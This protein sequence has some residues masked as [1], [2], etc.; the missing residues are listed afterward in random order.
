MPFTPDKPSSG[1]VPDSQPS[2]GNP[3]KDYYARHENDSVGQKLMDMVIA[4]KDN[5]MTGDD[6]GAANLAIPMEAAPAALQK[7]A[8]YLGG[9]GLGNAAARVAANTGIGAAQGGMADGAE[10]AKKGALIGG[11][12]STA[13][14]ALGGL[15]GLAKWGG[16]NL[17]RMTAPQ[18]DAYLDDPSAVAEMRNALED[19]SKMPALQDQAADAIRNSRAV[20]KAQ[21]L[22]KASQLRQALDGKYV[23][24]NPQELSG[25]S[26]EADKELA[27]F[28]Y[29]TPGTPGEAVMGDDNVMTR[30]N[31]TS[32]QTSMS[33]AVSV[34][35]NDANQLKRYLQGAAK[36]VPGSVTDPV[37]AARVKA[38]GQA[39]ANLRGGIEGVAPEAA[40]L[41]KQMQ[42]G[43]LLQEALRKGGKNS[44]LAFISS[45]SPDRVATLARAENAGAGGLLDFGNKL[46]AA[47]TMARP[48]QGSGIP[49][50][51]NKLAGRTIMR[52]A[53]AVQSAE[54]ANPAV[55]QSLIGG[56]F[57]PPAEKK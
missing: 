41:N 49:T 36:Y 4:P 24:I 23:P 6:L 52:G 2:S 43:M 25:L 53:D 10:G 37:Q 5:P 17:S 34:P 1:F 38:A 45:E 16:R 29:T 35:A 40:D 19:P 30:I 31:S 54:D 33:D 44:P 14:E 7:L 21:G 22:Q 15:M 3:I 28:S 46:G 27:A 48:D 9:S 8:A 12:L 26:P 39:A 57:S 47:K 20:L 32:P 51:L 18:A 42:E 13:G 11:A 55:I 50:F 56:L